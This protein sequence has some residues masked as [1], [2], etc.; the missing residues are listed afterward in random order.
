MGGCARVAACLGFQPEPA[1]A[2]CSAWCDARNVCD[3][4]EDQYLCERACTP[5][6][7]PLPAR[8]V[9]LEMSGCGSVDDCAAIDVAASPAC[10]EAC[11]GAGVCD[12]FAVDGTCEALCTGQDASFVTPEGWPGDIAACLGEAIDGDACNA[13]DVEGCFIPASCD[14]HEDL[15]IVGPEGGE[16]EVNTNGRADRY[17]A[18]CGGQG[19]EAV[20]AIQVRAPGR[21]TATVIAADYDPLIFMRQGTC[22]APQLE[23]ACNDDSAGVLSSVSVQAEVDI[24]YLF[25][26][27]FAGGSG[28]STVRI[29]IQ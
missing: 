2:A 10:I 13:A 27:G 22:D 21:L 16:F 29:T 23:V 12:Q 6:P 19:P 15:I 18:E 20:L 14:G 3:R 4:S 28:T 7:E 26:D 25:I 9:C 1:S 17:E 8:L 5:D 11:A 24:Y